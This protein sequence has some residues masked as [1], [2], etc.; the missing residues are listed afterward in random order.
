MKEL[1]ISLIGVLFLIQ[2]CDVC[3]QEM[4]DIRYS[5]T[6]TTDLELIPGGEFLMG[7]TYDSLD[8][9]KMLYLVDYY[10]HKVIIDS[11]YI[12]ACEVTNA[13][14]YE[15]CV[16]TENPLPEFWDIDTF[17]CSLKYPD[18]PV[19]GVTHFHASKYAEWKGMRLPTEAEWEFAARGGLQ[20]K[21]YPNGDNLDSTM[22]NSRPSG[23]GTVK[24][25]NYPPNAYGL[26]DMAGNVVEWVADYYSKD[27]FLVSP[28]N[29]PKGPPNGM[30]RVIR[31]GGWHSGP[32]CNRVYYRNHLKE[33]WVDFNLGFR[34]V[35][36]LR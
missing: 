33:W 36:D 12:Q 19:V 11:F 22:S 17:H 25:R 34:C 8:T 15:F 14:Y 16:A 24:V 10:V 27:Y 9:E 1:N 20:G 35:K 28:V 32:Y 23:C 26:Y 3:C 31:G 18:H 29:N 7:W 5:A 30:T 6:N 4:D 13:Q 2:L 21:K